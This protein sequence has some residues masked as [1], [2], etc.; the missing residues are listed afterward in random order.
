M[1]HKLCQSLLAFGDSFTYGV[2]LA[3]S[4]E[5]PSVSTWPALVAKKLG[6][7]YHCVAKGGV[8]N[9]WISYHV[10]ARYA[11]GLYKNRNLWCINWSWIERF[12]YIDSTTEDWSAIYP[13]HDDKLSHFFYRNLD[14]R[15]WNLFRNLE[16]IYS[17]IKFL[18]QHGCAFF[19]TC[20]DDTLFS[21]DYHDSHILPVSTLQNLV[22]P[23]IN[24][25][26][27]YGFYTWSIK[28]GF[29]T[30]PGGHPLE[31]A[32]SA[33]ADHIWQQVRCQMPIEDFSVL[34]QGRKLV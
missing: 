27:G 34:D 33:A 12:D 30:G 14:N 15:S 10:M 6:V 7:D 17:T 18:E 26:D 22:R 13:R 28:Q 1:D 3:D 20:I 11:R 19:M 24:T 29:D 2:E 8:G 5:S 16:I 31:S 25:F 23:Y 21:K 4:Q 9:Q 32:H